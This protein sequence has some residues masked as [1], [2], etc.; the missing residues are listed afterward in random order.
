[1]KLLEVGEVAACLGVS[2]LRVR[3]LANDGKLP[4]A[5]RTARGRRLFDPLAV[6]ALARQRRR[7]ARQ[8]GAEM[9]RH[10]RE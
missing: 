8:K 10:A 6:T 3:Q 5:V 1:M 4:V 7:S 2:T 9:R